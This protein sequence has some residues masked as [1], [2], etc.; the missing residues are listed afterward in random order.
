[1][2]S[3]VPVWKY[4]GYPGGSGMFTLDLDHLIEEKGSVE[5]KNAGL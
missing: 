5:I 2:K 4:S 1:M 3:Q